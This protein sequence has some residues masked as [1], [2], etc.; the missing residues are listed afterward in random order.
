[1]SCRCDSPGHQDTSGA[2]FRP[3]GRH[4]ALNLIRLNTSVKT[5]IKTKRLLAATSDQ[6]RATLLGL[7][8]D[9]ETDD[10]EEDE[11]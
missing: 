1:M 4:I 5:S 3:P 11:G 7:A 9:P 6:F 2:D 8:V 10:D